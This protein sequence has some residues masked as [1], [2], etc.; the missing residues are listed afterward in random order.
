V[1]HGYTRRRRGLFYLTWAAVPFLRETS[2]LRPFHL[3]KLE[4]SS[5]LLDFGNK[6]PIRK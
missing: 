3:R 4:F 5:V 1:A 2:R 6:R